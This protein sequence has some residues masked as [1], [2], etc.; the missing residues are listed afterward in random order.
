VMVLCQSAENDDTKCKGP[1]ARPLQRTHS[2]HGS[3]ELSQQLLARKSVSSSCL[4]PMH[5]DVNIWEQSP[6]GHMGI[7]RSMRRS[8]SGYQAV[9]VS[10]A[11]QAVSGA[12]WKSAN[13]STA[14]STMGTR[15]N[16][17]SQIRVRRLRR[18]ADYG[19]TCGYGS[20][21]RGHSCAATRAGEEV[22]ETKAVSDRKS[23]KARCN[24][25]PPPS[26]KAEDVPSAMA[27]AKAVATLQK[28]FFE[29][30]AKGGQDASGAAARALLRMNEAAPQAPAIDAASGS[31]S[32][33]NV[34][35]VTYN[36]ASD[37]S[38]SP[39]HRPMVPQV[40]PPSGANGRRRPQPARVFCGA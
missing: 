36:D 11:P 21:H 7:M 4:S 39:V 6:P 37:T 33:I 27:K 30:M 29:E 16:S 17:Q 8:T 14:Q 34:E 38:S 18:P 3:S 26:A 13:D 31:V 9:D 20:R 1:L 22:E 19:A 10:M 32:Y 25:M 23:P 2:V 15:E 12:A 24:S 5:R 40:P 28:L 35:T